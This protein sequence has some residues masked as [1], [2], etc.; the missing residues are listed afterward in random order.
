MTQVLAPCLELLGSLAALFAKSYQGVPKAMRVAI[1]NTRAFKSFPKYAA[2]SRG[3]APLLARK[4]DRFK[5]ARFT[6]SNSRSRKQRII[7]AP[8]QFL[9][10][11]R[12]PL[13]KNQAYIIT[14]RE[15]IGRERLAEFGK[16]GRDAGNFR[17]HQKPAGL[18]MSELFEL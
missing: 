4:S 16:Q 11:E 10:Q 1:P 7:V 6:D 9:L 2:Y 3:R 17:D 14:N 5:L 8:K 13:L 12:H 18:L 15:E